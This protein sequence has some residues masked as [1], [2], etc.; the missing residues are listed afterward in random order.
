MAQIR[1]EAAGPDRGKKT[2][3]ARAAKLLAVLKGL[4]YAGAHIGGP[5]LGFKDIDFLLNEAEALAGDWQN[6][7][8]DVSFRPEKMFYFFEKDEQTGLNRPVPVKTGRPGITPSPVYG[9]S[10]LVHDLAFKENSMLCNSLKSLCQTLEQSGHRSLPGGIEHLIKFI[11]YGCRNCGDCT[12]AEIAFLCPQSGCAKYLLNGPCG[13][14][15]DGW[16]EVYPGKKRCLYVLVYERLKARQRQGEMRSGYIP[17]RDWDLNNTSSWFNF[18][19]G[20]DHLGRK[21]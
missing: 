20:R 2:R 10:R 5:G 3:L 14:S 7:L 8:A 1:K 17:P 9:L 18:F 21:D 6:L 11:L 4:G 16:C 15:R 12:L 13:G 19:L